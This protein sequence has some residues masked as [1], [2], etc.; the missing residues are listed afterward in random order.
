MFKKTQSDQ[1][2]CL[3]KIKIY[4]GELIQENCLKA[5]YSPDLLPANA[6]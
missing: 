6:E 2:A 3:W 5:H 4:Q 1:Y